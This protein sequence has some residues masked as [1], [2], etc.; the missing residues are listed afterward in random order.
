M[1]DFHQISVLVS[2]VGIIALILHVFLQHVQWKRNHA[3]RFVSRMALPTF[4]SCCIGHVE[5]KCLQCAQPCINWQQLF[6]RNQKQVF[7]FATCGCRCSQL[8]NIIDIKRSQVYMY[9]VYMMCQQKFN[10]EVNWQKWSNR[11]SICTSVL[12]L[13]TVAMLEQD[14]GWLKT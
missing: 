5:V 14:I 1:P 11:D 6:A 2:V 7:F 4:F 9:R 10:M 12:S 3:P 8:Y 13:P